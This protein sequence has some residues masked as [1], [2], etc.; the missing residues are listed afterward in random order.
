MHQRCLAVFGQ[1]LGREDPTETRSVMMDSIRTVVQARNSDS[2]HLAL[3]P[4]QRARVVHQLTVKIVVVPHDGRVHGVNLDDVVRI[5]H[6]FG[7]GQL[8]GW[9]VSDEGHGG[10]PNLVSAINAC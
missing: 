7:R 4:T 3:P 2:Q 5:G 1:S 10:A 9:D 8:V 6:A